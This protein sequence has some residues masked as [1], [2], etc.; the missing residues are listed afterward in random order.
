M[1]TNDEALQAMDDIMRMAAQA[2]IS[3]RASEEEPSSADQAMMLNQILMIDLHTSVRGGRTKALRVLVAAAGVAASLAVGGVL[4]TR[5]GDGPDRAEAPTTSATPARQSPQPE[6]TEAVPLEVPTTAVQWL[7]ARARGEV[8]TARLVG[9]FTYDA[10]ETREWD[11]PMGKAQM[12][13]ISSINGK[14]HEGDT[15]TAESP[16]TRQGS[17]WGS[18]NLNQGDLYLIFPASYDPPT[19]IVSD[20]IYRHKGKD[21]YELVNSTGS[22][23]I[24]PHTISVSELRKLI[25]D[26]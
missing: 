13:V 12:K 26:K 1:Q 2:G 18:P 21:N 11:Q 22:A 3:P 5:A 8:V 20:D 24:Q 6:E 10:D 19:Y 4:L 17:A 15:F 9:G 14:L 7:D 25:E 23:K 16:L